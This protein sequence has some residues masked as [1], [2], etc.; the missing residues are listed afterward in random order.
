MV[1]GRL[2]QNRSGE[3]PQ[4]FRTFDIVRN[5]DNTISIFTTN[6]DTD[7]KNSSFAEISRHYALASAQILGLMVPDPITGPATYN[8]ELKVP[9]SP[10]MQEKIKNY[11]TL[12]N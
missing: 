6:V 4:Q 10:E 8:A 12:I 11:G 2:K 1:F 3:F 9:L 5:S 7:V